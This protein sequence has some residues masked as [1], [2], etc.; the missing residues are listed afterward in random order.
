MRINIEF[1][2]VQELIALMDHYIMFGWQKEDEGE[3]D[4]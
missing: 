1:A 3:G 4:P 2:S